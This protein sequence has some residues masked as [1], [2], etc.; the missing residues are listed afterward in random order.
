MKAYMLSWILPLVLQSVSPVITE[1]IKKLVGLIF[2]R[3]PRS[4][5]TVLAAAVAEIVNLVP[6]ALA[7][8]GLPPGVG[9]LIAVAFNEF[10]NDLTKGLK[11]TL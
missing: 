6:Q 11:S 7:G 2:A 5:I 10:Y 4:A 1:T 9:G 3:L 8:V